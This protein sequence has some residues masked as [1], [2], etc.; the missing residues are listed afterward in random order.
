MADLID[1]Q[2]A[3]RNFCRQQC[4]CDPDECDMKYESKG[5]FSEIECCLSVAF[6]KELPTIDAVEVV[7]CR[8]CKY[9]SLSGNELA[10]QYKVAGC[11]RLRELSVKYPMIT[12]GN[13]FCNWGE[14]RTDAAD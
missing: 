8:D 12:D 13:G 14:R 6:L 10:K 3:I 11:F 4:D 2:A 7:R 9:F 5:L 1:R